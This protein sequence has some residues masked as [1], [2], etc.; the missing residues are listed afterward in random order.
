MVT[1]RIREAPPTCWQA[2]LR[3]AAVADVV[4]PLSAEDRQ[5]ISFRHRRHPESDGVIEWCEACGDSWP[6]SLARYEATCAVLEAA[7][8]A[9]VARRGGVKY[10]RS[11]AH[12][13]ERALRA[14]GAL[15]AAEQ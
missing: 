13:A 8:C 12:I 4:L 10:A 3:R 9:I 14:V 15:P 7:L 2:C 1:A 5:A 11:C 6:C